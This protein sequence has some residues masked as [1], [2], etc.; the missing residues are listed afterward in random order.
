MD[1]HWR[2]GLST[3]R[4]RA[5]TAR[6]TLNKNP[7]RCQHQFT[8]AY[9]QSPCQLCSISCRQARAACTMSSLLPADILHEASTERIPGAI[10]VLIDS[11]VAA[12]D[13]DRDTSRRYL[14]RASA[15]L[16]AQCATHSDSKRGREPQPSGGLATWQVTRVVDYIEQHLGDKI[17]GQHL[18]ELVNVSVGQMFRAFKVSVGVSPFHYIARRRIEFACALLRTTQ[19][20]LAQVAIAS[21]LCDQSHLCRVFRRVMGVTPA[22]WRR[23]NAND[24]ELRC[25]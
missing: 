8:G 3:Q 16:R 18:A 9:G 19:E 23:A 14:L 25:A 10:S 11:A 13:A 21:G 6:Q 7:R 4:A 20:S 17:T 2:A 15:I 12:F 24:P 5:A 22:M 1:C